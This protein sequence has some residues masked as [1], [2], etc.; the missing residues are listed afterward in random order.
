MIKYSTTEIARMLQNNE[1]TSV[2]LVNLYIAQNKKVNPNLNAMSYNC[3]SEALKQAEKC[4]QERTPDKP[5]LYGIPFISKECYE[6]PDK[7]FTCGILA[8]KNIKGINT[9]EVLQKLIDQGG[10]VLCAGNLSE[11][12]M[13][14]ES[15]N[16]VY[17]RTNNPYD[18]T[19]TAGGSSG[20][21][22]AL[23]SSA[24]GAFGLT[25]DVGGSTRIPAFYN[26]YFGLK[27]TGGLVS[28]KNCFPK[29][30]GK[31]DYYCQLGPSCRF[32]EDLYPLVKLM[33][34]EN[35]S[36]QNPNKVDIKNLRVIYLDNSFDSFLI[37]KRTPELKQGELK[38]LETFEKHGCQIEIKRYT[39]L[40]KG[41]FYWSAGMSSSN[42]TPFCKLIEIKPW[43][44]LFKWFFGKSNHTLPAIGLCIL[45]QFTNLTSCF[46]RSQIA[47]GEKLKQKIKKD[48]D[49]STIIICPSLPEPAPPHKHLWKKLKIL[50]CTF[51][52]I[53]NFLEFP[54]LQVPLG[55]NKEGLPLGVQIVAD[56]HN[57]HLCIAAAEFLESKGIAKHV[58]PPNVD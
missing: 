47:A 50:D 41:F 12:A 25:S 43:S 4:D 1:V 48:L 33:V 7:P 22:G 32:S 31:I 42:Q 6:M 20:G 23:I 29:S 15:D 58:S 2:Q 37:S 16:P 19:R 46:N 54:A 40:S 38:V 14:M 55:L 17:G 36:I 10:I 44:E 9:C 13:W 8:R 56:H 45:E 34:K 11:G 26:G 30:E 5:F 27:P 24:C 57:D 52:C 18:L 35:N 28:N 3:F 21:T 49:S 51:T 53:F 39:D